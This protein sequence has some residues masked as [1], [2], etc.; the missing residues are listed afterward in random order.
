MSMGDRIQI[1]RKDL[2][3]TQGELAQLAG[4]S[5]GFLSDVENDKRGIGAEPLLRIADSLSTSIQYLLTGFSGNSPVVA[6]PV[7][8][9]LLITYALQADLPMR[10]TITLL[11]VRQ[12]IE[13][14]CQRTHEF[15][16]W[17]GLHKALE[18]FL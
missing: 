6:D 12:C 13:N 15:T 4:L 5:K 10:H 16:A 14:H 7:I 3:L 9:P 11:R 17:E 1:R 8:P 18:S 2:K